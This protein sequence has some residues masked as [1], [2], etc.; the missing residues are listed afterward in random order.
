MNPDWLLKHFEQIS[1]A[2]DAVRRLRRFILDLAVRGKLVEQDPKDEPAS[3]LLKRLRAQS[4]QLSETRRK[5]K[6]NSMGSLK[7]SECPFELPNAW[8]WIGLGEVSTLI[9]KGSTPT[10]YG[11]VFVKSG[12]NFV[13]IEAIKDARISAGNITSYISEETHQF[14][15]RS[16]LHNGDFLFSIAGSI[17]TC[18][19]VTDSILPAN[20]NQ[21][22]AIIRGVD[23]AFL[24]SFLQYATRSCLL[25]LALAKARGGAM[26]N[27]FLEDVRNFGLPLPP[28]P[29]QHRI[30]AKVDELMAL[31]D[32]LEAAQQ[33]QEL[34][35]D[36]LVAAVLN[37]L[38]NGDGGSGPSNR[39]DFQESARFYFNHLPRLT[40][41]PEHIQQLRQTILNLAVR[42]KL[43]PQNPHDIPTDSLISC[44]EAERKRRGSAGEPVNTQALAYSGDGG[45][46]IPQSWRWGRLGFVTNVLM[47]QSPPGETYNT[48]GEGIPLINGPV[49]FSEGPFGVTVLNQYTTAPTKLCKK[50]DLLLC[51]RGSTTGRTNIAG[52]DA[53]IGRG[54]AALQS[55]YTDQYIRLFVWLWRDKIIEMGRGIAFPS[56]SRQQ[57]EDLPIPLPPLAEQHRIVAK[58]DEL[59]AICVELESRLS[60]TATTRRQLLEA[61]LS[62]AIAL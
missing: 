41:R 60:T 57:I 16:Q 12:I 24:V 17:G 9:T 11:H 2:P 40:T 3:E 43:V 45:F 47:G 58:V 10:S 28:L 6:E 18:A 56:I 22:L 51:V 48:H 23:A 32:E 49:E 62:E 59:M 26:N 35:R 39:S 50:G 33:K 46:S 44:I 61:T 38:N 27:I 53:C 36:R 55:F 13:K 7:E 21:A 5:R 31:C 20:I 54:V 8:E 25:E 29:E 37:G 34:R 30:V 15:K 42:G 14:L 1:E 19:V 52:F 4:A